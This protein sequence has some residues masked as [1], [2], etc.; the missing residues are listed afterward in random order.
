MSWVP[1]LGMILGC[2]SHDAAAPRTRTLPSTAAT[3]AE[4]FRS[5]QHVCTLPAPTN[6]SRLE[7]R[8][9]VFTELILLE[10]PSATLNAARVAD[11]AALAVDPSLE[12][13]AA[14]HVMAHLGQRVELTLVDRI[15]AAREA[16]LH[17]LRVL[18]RETSDGAVVL[19]LQVTF[20]LP[21]PSGGVPAPTATVT[22][23]TTGAEQQLL[24]TTTALPHARGRG[25]LALLK[26]WRVRD[27]LDLRAIF[28]CKMRERQKAISRQ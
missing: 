23:T 19:E 16:S 17:Q 24:L 18:P 14:P 22:L 10:G 15:G 25:L 3:R 11:L 27:P 6:P 7:D 1:V 20:Q 28:E 12:L 9:E 13:L 2:G 21:N 26:Y 5:A 8:Y 4:L